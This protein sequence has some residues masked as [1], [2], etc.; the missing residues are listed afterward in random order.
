M[1]LDSHISALLYRYDCVIIPQFGGFVANYKPA[2]IDSRLNVLHPPSKGIIFNKNLT[3]ND[4]LLANEIVVKESKNFEE[5]NRAIN[6]CVEAYKA[7]LSKGNRIEIE[8]VGILYYD[9]E[10][11]I[12]FQPNKEINYLTSAFGLTSFYLPPV[13]STVDK[14]VEKENVE[15]EE[16]KVI[17]I[18]AV[19]EKE[20]EKV[21]S[22]QEKEQS[23]KVIPITAKTGDDRKKT[24]VWRYVAAAVVILPITFYSVWIPL[25]TDAV[26]TRHLE[27]ADFNPFNDTTPSLYQERNTWSNEA[28]YLVEIDANEQAFELPDTVYTTQ[29]SFFDNREGLTVKLREPIAEATPVNTYVAHDVSNPKLRYHLI[30]GCFQ[31]LDNAEKLVNELRTKGYGARIIDEHKGLHRVAFGSFATRKEAIAVM[32][33]IKEDEEA[34]VWVLKK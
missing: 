11:N 14:K 9:V 18:V 12:Q 30:G 21:A 25:K 4:G 15:H 2:Y 23:E 17:P 22:T 7:T 32:S 31:Y 13:E 19:K 29:L 26:K 27:L 33:M 20:V 16:V 24:K 6:Q 34:S 10:Q 5:A 3:N 1:K 28:D 8:K